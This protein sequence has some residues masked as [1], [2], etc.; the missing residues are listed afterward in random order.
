MLMLFI[1]LPLSET[2]VVSTSWFSDCFNIAFPF[3]L[4]VWLVGVRVLDQFSLSLLVALENKRQFG[5]IG[6][7]TTACHDL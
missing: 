2:E 4:I 1:H 7:P 6:K 3:P 5:V